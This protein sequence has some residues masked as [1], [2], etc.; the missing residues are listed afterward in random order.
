MSKMAGCNN[1]CLGDGKADGTPRD[2]YPGSET[3]SKGVR[4]GL[5]V[6]VGHQPQLQGWAPA[7]TCMVC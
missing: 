3:L 7:G 4:K 6:G 2:H 5:L 1:R